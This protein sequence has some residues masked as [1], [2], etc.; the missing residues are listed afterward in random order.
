MNIFVRIDD[1]IIT[2]PTTDTI[3]DGITRKSII[4]IAEDNNIK[5]EV[6]LFLLMRLLKLIQRKLKEIFGSGTAVVVSEISSFGYRGKNY[7]LK[8]IENSYAQL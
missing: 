3:L 5:V 7:N 6:S 1:T 2:A 8:K 4:K